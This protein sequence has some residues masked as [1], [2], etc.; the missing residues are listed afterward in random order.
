VA[1]VGTEDRDEETDSTSF[2]QALPHRRRAYMLVRTLLS[3]GCEWWG[4]RRRKEM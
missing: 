4:A 2:L 1:T 3:R